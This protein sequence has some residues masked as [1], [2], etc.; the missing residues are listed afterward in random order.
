MRNETNTIKSDIILNG[1]ATLSTYAFSFLIMFYVSRVL[2][3]DSMGKVGFASSVISYFALFANMGIPIYGMRKCAQYKEDREKL[4]ILV[5]ELLFLGLGLSLITGGVLWML[6][7]TV[8]RLQADRSLLFLLSISIFLQAAGCEWL[9]K[10]LGRFSYLAVRTIVF[11]TAVFGLILLMIRQQ[12]DFLRYAILTV[13]A[14]SGMY[15]VNIVMLHRIVSFRFFRGKY[16]LLQHI[17]PI[18]VFFLMSCATTIY[19]KMDLVM[20]GFIGSEYE[21][22]CYDVVEKIKAMMTVVGAVIWNATLP[23]ASSCWKK[24]EYGKFRQLGKQSMADILFLQVPL[25]LFSVYNARDIILFVAGKQYLDA[26]LPL[27][28]ILLSIPPIAI[29]NIMGGQML[30]PAEKEKK[31]LVSEAAGVFV[32]LILNFW[33]IPKWGMAGAACSTVLAE[34]TVT[35]VVWYYVAKDLNMRFMAE[36]GFGKIL[37]SSF[38]ALGL[39]VLFAE[40]MLQ[41]ET[42]FINLA[43]K[44]AFFGICYLGVLGIIGKGEIL[45]MRFVW[46]KIIGKVERTIRRRL[47]TEQDNTPILSGKRYCTCCGHNVRKMVS[48]H[49]D[50]RPDRYDLSR[51][52]KEREAVLCPNCGSLPRHRI[53]AEYLET[54]PY[55]IKGRRAILYFAEEDC[56]KLWMQRKGISYET[57]D[58]NK[59]ADL[60]IDIQA[61]GLA[62]K[63]QDLII[64]NHVLEH[65]QDFRRAL[66]ELYR[67]LSEDGLLICSFPVDE[68]Y[69]T[70]YEN[71][72]LTAPDERKK[73]FGQSD[74]LRIFGRNVSALLAE[75][76]FE[77]ECFTG[78]QCPPQ[79]LPITGPADYDKDILFLCR[80]GKKRADTRPLISVILPVYN[81]EE[82]LEKCVD[83][84]LNQTYRNLEILLV[85]DGSKD[86]SGSICDRYAAM[87]NRVRVFHQENRGLSAA[88]NLGIEKGRG[89]YI[90]FVDSDDEIMP[91]MIDNLY[92]A[93]EREQTKVS[94]CGYYRDKG[95]KWTVH[96]YCGKTV[97]GREE[98]MHSLFYDSRLGV[99]AWNKLYSRDLLTADIFPVGR[100]YEDNAAVTEILGKCD[101]VAVTERPGYFH[102]YR[103]DS[104]TGTI[105]GKKMKDYCL[106]TESAEQILKEVCPE[107]YGDEKEH[108]IRM[109][110]RD[111]K[112]WIRIAGQKDSKDEEVRKIKEDC[113]K[114][115]REEKILVKEMHNQYGFAGR[116]IIYFPQLLAKIIRL[117]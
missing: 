80:K 12:E 97:L 1:A 93:L 45:E 49:Y 14:S 6:T 110:K 84:V 64:C 8:S 77:T 71:Q 88:R 7:N 41:F 63:S 66:R 16:N 10:A 62:E 51:Y 25:C 76:G 82:Y 34:V 35:A 91:D 60:Q 38:S 78:A 56:M 19:G 73:E 65:V 100:Y 116:M 28:I 98:V 70:V 102:R 106:A 74:H 117:I 114:R 89:A 87:D 47:Y 103:E 46:H 13:A 85:D 79:I 21:V 29:S 81:V 50:R 33:L 113:T 31:L 96:R 22:G 58:L 115:I 83:S 2:G 57:A 75:A 4:S 9:F 24:K 53:L 69:E 52:S 59:R 26:V 23:K 5:Q 11:K 44:A 15:L 95:K 101:R 42:V 92:S 108:R 39:L 61:T 20:L 48:G 43:W 104:I 94:I 86:S 107:V 3:P 112:L 36:T 90:S 32:N 72:E 67:I 30:I 111:I 105:S 68:R 55:E 109:T 27:Q 40:K 54:H 37:V 18:L 17:R 99:T